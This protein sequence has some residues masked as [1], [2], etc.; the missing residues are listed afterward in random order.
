MTAARWNAHKT[1][2]ILRRE[3]PGVAAVFLDTIIARGRVIRSVYDKFD[4]TPS[5]T[6]RNHTTRYPTGVA[7]LRYGTKTRVCKC[8]VS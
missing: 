2:P 7:L 6:K 1:A 8:D 4:G 5:P 3:V